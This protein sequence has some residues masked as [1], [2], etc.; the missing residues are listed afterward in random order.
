MIVKLIYRGSIRFNIDF[1]H[2]L[3]RY[4]IYLHIY[5]KINHFW[6]I[7]AC[8]T[9]IAKSTYTP[10]EVSLYDKVGQ[11]QTAALYTNSLCL[12]LLTLRVLIS[13]ISKSIRSIYIHHTRRCI[14]HFQFGIYNIREL[15]SF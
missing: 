15:L 4:K 11:K 9:I 8:R 3:P 1:T 12:S 5:T 2:I 7:F 13:R 14:S 6:K 10:L